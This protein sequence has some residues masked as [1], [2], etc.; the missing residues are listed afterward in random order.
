MSIAKISFSKVTALLAV[1]ALVY[2]AM[3][4]EQLAAQE[5][6]PEASDVATT[7]DA[8]LTRVETRIIQAQDYSQHHIVQGQI[9]A[10]RSVD[11][12]TQ[13]S[14]TVESLPVEQGE[15]VKAGQLLL[16]LSNAEYQAQVRSTEAEVKL[17]R[18]ELAAAQRLKKRNMQT[19]TEVLRLQSELEGAKSAL[20]QARL[21]LQHSTPTAPFTGVLDKN[22]AEIGQFLTAGETWARL[23]NIDRLKVTAQIPQQSVAAVAVGQQ[24]TVTLLNGQEL[25][26][27][28][29]FIASAAETGTRSFPIEVMLPNPDRQRIAGASATLDIDLGSVRAHK[30]TPALLSLNSHGQLGVKWVDQGDKVIFQRV[31]LLSTGT[32]GAWIKGL[33]DQVEV[34]TL[35]GG[36]VKEGEQVIATLSVD[37]SANPQEMSG[38][39]GASNS[40]KGNGVN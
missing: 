8:A 32:D 5:K 39:S 22:D 1:I 3:T 17:K 33:P 36:F 9:E 38:V 11:L 2:W 34:I 12:R 15:P 28:V 27:T 24:V 19:E 10:W 6:A 16:K 20:T 7:T 25:S 26:G 14:G 31:E 40:A 21:Q 35:G 18:A 23:V 30:V 13:V 29:S 4:A 37:Q